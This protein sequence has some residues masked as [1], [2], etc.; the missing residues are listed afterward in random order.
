MEAERS[1]ERVLTTQVK[2]RHLL[3]FKTVAECGALSRAAETL[4]MSQPAVSKTI[5]EL[6]TLLG[7]RLLER[8][9]KGVIPTVFGSHVLRYAHSL[10]AELKR[11]AE[12]LTALR[13]GAAG[14]LAIGSYMVALPTLL[15]RALSLFFAGGDATRV[16]VVDGS[17]ERLL[18]GLQSGEIDIVVGRMS[19]QDG[20]GQIRQI[21]LYFEPIVLVAGSQNPLA[22][23]ASPTPADLAAQEW[24]MPHASSV[25]R[26]PI[27]MFFA[28]E[29]LD[30]PARIVETLSFP[31]IRAL[32]LQ[33][34]I[35]AALPW[36]IVQADIEQGILAKLPVDI[37][38]PA[39]PVGIITHAHDSLSAAALRMVD[40]LKQAAGELYHRPP[41]A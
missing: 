25:A 2:L 21:P 17:K 3:M 30:L 6:E 13:Q 29:G 22:A 40:N 19:E 5:H 36:Q 27:H 15:P 23:K 9:A 10:H 12:E 34:N 14:K 24:V 38:Y 8:T 32:L 11:A 37:G 33:R 20:H 28:R 16:S 4:H 18:S 1:I 35:V 41:A 7:E 39:L 26:T 31:L